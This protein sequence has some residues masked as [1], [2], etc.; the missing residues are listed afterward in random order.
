MKTQRG[1]YCHA[2]PWLGTK[3][4]E[5]GITHSEL[6]KI[7]GLHF[8]GVSNITRGIAKIPPKHMDKIASILAADEQHKSYII[9]KM[10]ELTLRD[11]EKRI[12][13]ALVVDKAPRVD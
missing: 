9:E 7:L 13:A 3:L 8:Q 10:I 2:G 6:A 4:K 12:R 1:F 11:E 5:Q